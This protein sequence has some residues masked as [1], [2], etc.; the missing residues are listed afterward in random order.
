[1][2]SHKRAF[3]I[4]ALAMVIFGTLAFGP[5]STRNVTAVQAAPEPPA[6]IIVLCTTVA[7]LPAPT[8]FIP[9]VAERVQDSD[10][11]DTWVNAIPTGSATSSCAYALQNVF[12]HGFRMLGSAAGGSTNDSYRTAGFTDQLVHTTQYTLVRGGFWAVQ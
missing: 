5:L 6:T 7:Q 12:D 11:T 2:N 3:L 10:P 8:Q 9:P 4:V 1:M